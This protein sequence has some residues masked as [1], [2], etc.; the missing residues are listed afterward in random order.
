MN[1][2]V[3]SLILREVS[4]V[5]IIYVFDPERKDI[6]EYKLVTRA[7]LCNYSIESEQVI[8]YDS[9][10][11]W[12]GEK[13]RL[14]STAQQ[15]LIPLVQQHPS[16]TVYFGNPLTNPVAQ[17]LKR[18]VKVNHLYHAPSDFVGILSP[19]SSLL[20]TGIKNLVNWLLYRDVYQIQS[21][22]LPVF[23]LLNLV[24]YPS[25]KFLDFND[26]SSS[27]VE[28]VLGELI[29]A[30]RCTG[31]NIMLLLAGD[32]P[33][34]GDN[35]YSNISKY[36]Q[37]HADA[38]E[39][40]MRDKNLQGATVW[41][42]EHRSYRP[43]ELK[44]RLQ[45]RCALELQAVRVEFISDYI[46]RTYRLLPGECIIRYCKFDHVV[47]EPSSLLLNISHSIKASLAVSQFV[48]F[49]DDNQRNR[50][51][52]MVYLNSLLAEPCEVL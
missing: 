12:G 34:P 10:R 41:V 45:L 20:K 32:E 30:V 37:P 19:Q 9:L 38:L 31:K 16:G 14:L 28:K 33:A 24:S 4:N 48:P 27:T 35:N 40:L 49:R 44:E 39:M 50:N 2:L 29:Q 18:L 5:R 8:E 21:G 22:D 13:K 51:R 17:A 47:A 3:A 15:T 46:P 42:K 6:A 26:F 36:L 1:A 7:L 11:F 43:L 25:F 52:E 23:S